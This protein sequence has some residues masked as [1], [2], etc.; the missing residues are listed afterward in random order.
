MLSRKVERLDSMKPWQPFGN[1]EG[2]TFYL[3]KAE[4]IT[5]DLPYFFIA[6]SIDF[7]DKIN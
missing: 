4:K 5:N 2:A 6:F 7:Y 1:E 3:R